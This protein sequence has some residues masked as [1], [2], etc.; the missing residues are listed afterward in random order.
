[1]KKY[2]TCLSF[3]LLAACAKENNHETIISVQRIFGECRANVPVNSAPIKNPDGECEIITH[4]LDRFQSENPDVKLDINIAAWPGYDQLS[5]QL[6]AGDPPDIVTMHMSALPD[7]QTR[8]LVQPLSQKFSEIGIDKNSFTKAAI[9]GVTINNE[10]YGLPFDNWTQLWHINTKLFAK[11]GLMKNGEPILPSSEEEFIAHAIK[12]KKA[13]GLPYL[14]QA[15]ANEQASYTRNLYTYLKDQNSNFFADTSKINLNTP[16]ANR[17]VKLFTKLYSEKLMS[18][19]QDYPAATQA[20]I[21]GE[22]GVYQVG[23]WMIGTFNQEANTK[24]QALYDSY[25]V[26]PYPMLYGDVQQSYVDGHTWV[27]TNKKR[28]D[29]QEKAVLRLMKFLYENDYEWARSGHLPSVQ[30][31]AQSPK[32]LSLPYRKYIISLSE[33]GS[34][35]PNGVQR[36]FAISDIIGD[37]MSSAIT[38]FKT[39]Q[40]ALSDAEHRI[41]DLLFHLTITNKTEK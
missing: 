36:Q 32:Y 29:A 23:T 38:G 30:T 26:R 4:L 15:T 16:E 6:A 31:I 34:T 19:N 12:F 35:L 24:G 2:I 10:I 18:Q 8:G 7:Y 40:M 27:K 41:N 25:T 3:I 21:N 20:F 37:E 5:A 14:I 33:S 17:I 28:S 11:A 22:G 13:T 39:S 9:N 1:M